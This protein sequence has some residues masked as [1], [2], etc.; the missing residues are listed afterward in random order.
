MRR[1][2]EEGA[3]NTAVFGEQNVMKKK[4]ATDKELL[5]RC[6]RITT[7]MAAFMGITPQWSICVMLS[8]LT[9]DGGEANSAASVQWPVLYKQA[10]IF[11][12][13]EIVRTSTDSEL[14][15]IVIHELV[16]ILYA[17]VEDMLREEIGRNSYVR[18]RLTDIQENVCD[19][20]AHIILKA[21]GEGRPPTYSRDKAP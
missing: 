9:R 18:M 4:K 1:V 20:I 11:F 7:D 2:P 15:A 6:L 16:H 10:T 17:P 5:A 21:L 13:R 3:V 19:S 14:L 12:D 8:A